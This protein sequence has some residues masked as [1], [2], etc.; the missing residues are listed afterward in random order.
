MPAAAAARWRPAAGPTRGSP[1]PG[2]PRGQAGAHR[3]TPW[4]PPLPSA[5]PFGRVGLR[6][7]ARPTLESRYISIRYPPSRSR[8][9]PSPA[10]G[11]GG[12]T[13]RGVPGEF[14]V[15]RGG[16][17]GDAAPAEVGRGPLAPQPAHLGG[18]ALIG[19]QLVDGAGQGGRIRR[20]NQQAG[21]PVRP[22]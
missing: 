11:P 6:P 12:L 15:E 13:G 22:P 17:R 10:R 5:P 7:R 3:L 2:D 19:R 20:R 9:S 14:R 16:L 8:G 18:P 21:L 1:V 4:E